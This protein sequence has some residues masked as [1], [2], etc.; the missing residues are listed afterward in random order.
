MM[1]PLLVW[2][3][4]ILIVL[5]IEI[6]LYLIL[7]KQE[8]PIV[9]Y[10]ILSIF[11]VGVIGTI[12]IGFTLLSS[13]GLIEEVQGAIGAEQRSMDLPAVSETLE[14]NIMRIVLETNGVPSKIEGSTANE[15]HVFGLY[16]ATVHP[17]EKPLITETGDYVQTKVV[18]DTM[19]VTLKEP[20]D[21]IGPFSTY[22]TMEPTI[23]VP[24]SIQLE[25]RGQHS[26]VSLYPGSLENNWIVDG[27]SDVM[28]HINDKS[29][30]LLS[31]VSQ[32]DL[33]NGNVAWDKI[34]TTDRDRIDEVYEE[35][36][37]EKLYKG[38]KKLGE[39]TYKLSIFN[40]D[41]V[42]VNLVEKL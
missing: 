41:L 8:N 32:N 42:T 23:I 39:G 30:I 35:S 3:P 21:K 37:T 6:V 31:A 15:L 16:R 9:K 40:S 11:F 5:G 27:A 1:E 29:N 18:G 20:T 13:I 24:S 4:L 12:G 26:P 19:Y 28:V 17:K 2:W 7:S 36:T 22:T 14:S 10:D 38:T 25:V 34:D 33:D